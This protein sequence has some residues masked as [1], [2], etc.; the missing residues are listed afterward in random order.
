MKKVRENR[1]ITLIALVI[2]I[3]VLLI[4]AGI[5]LNLV[6]GER[7]IFKMAQEAGRNYTNAASYEDNML[8]KITSEAE[9]IINGGIRKFTR[10]CFSKESTNRRLCSI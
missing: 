4:L 8:D 9:G 1:A 3:I 10:K 2:T 6:L 7:G 5:T